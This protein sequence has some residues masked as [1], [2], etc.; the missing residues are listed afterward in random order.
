MR[1]LTVCGIA[2]LALLASVATAAPARDRI[3]MEYQSAR[4]AEI[5]GEWDSAL[6]HYETIYDSM[7][8]PQT[9]RL[10]LRKKLA[11]LHPKVEPN[12]DPA[13]AGS[14]KVRV[15]VFR[16]LHVQ[17]MKDGKQI[18]IQNTY[19]DDAIEGIRRATEGFANVVW[20][21]T[22]GS[23]KIDWDLRVI[24]EPLTE[25]DGWPDPVNVLPHIKDLGPRDVD[26]I[27]VYADMTNVEPWALWAG[28]LGSVP[29]IGGAAYIGFN[30]TKDGLSRNPVGE[31]QVHEWLHAAQWCLEVN[32]GYPPH[33]METSDC[34]GKC[35]G[36]EGVPCW[37]RNPDGPEGWMDLYWHM[38]EVHATR[39]MWREMSFLHPV[40][41]AWGNLYCHRFELLGPFDATGMADYGLGKAW[42]DETTP[43]PLDA[44]VAG[45]AWKELETTTRG[46]DF[47]QVLGSR[48]NSVA[49][50][51]ITVSSE[52]KVD[53]Q[54][55]MGTDDSCKLWQEGKLLF[56]FPELRGTTADQ[57]TVPVTLEKGMNHFLLNVAQAGGGWEAIFR[58]CDAEG[59]PVPGVEY[60]LLPH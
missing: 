56:T 58:I 22:L 32:D 59:S 34:G 45:L 14:Y 46:V 8:V 11:E 30:D 48:E 1:V 41:N 31:V 28:T 20:E 38:L 2:L 6:L 18:D 3:D 44:Q 15:Y 51:A 9:E 49:Y 42:I 43:D 26:C 35:S 10:E 33:L 13:N 17:R 57:D 37:V 12:T 39:K 23:L 24:E 4:A 40:P 5:A 7:I 25:V 60:V 47:M 53:A 19:T 55:R 54:V 27:F 29:E 36:I 21:H 52:E 16:T 50:L